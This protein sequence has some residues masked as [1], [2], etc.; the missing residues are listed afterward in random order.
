MIWRYSKVR[1]RWCDN[2]LM[3]INMEK[4]MHLKIRAKNVLTSYKMFD[5][6][7]HGD[8]RVAVLVASVTA[9]S[10]FMQE[11]WIPSRRTVPVPLS[12]RCELNCGHLFHMGF[13]FHSLTG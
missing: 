13:E 8:V 6:Q 1:L 3:V 2:N 12:R 9:P 5:L 4:T 11:S 10:I 7:R